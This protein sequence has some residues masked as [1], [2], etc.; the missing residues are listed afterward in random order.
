M[1]PIEWLLETSDNLINLN[2]I[3]KFNG[4]VLCIEVTMHIMEASVVIF[5]IKHNQLYQYI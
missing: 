2:T 4:Y 3:L 1:P 5:F